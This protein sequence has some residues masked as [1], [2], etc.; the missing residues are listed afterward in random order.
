MPFDPYTFNPYDPRFQ[1]LMAQRMHAMQ[2]AQMPPQMQGPPPVAGQQGGMG[3]P[4]PQPQMPAPNSAMQSMLPGGSQLDP[5]MVD[6]VLALQGQG[7]QRDSVSRQY[8]L[9]DALR[10]SARDQ[11]QS[12]PGAKL[13]TGGTLHQGPT[14]VNGLS[15]VAQN[16]KAGQMQDAADTS[17]KGLDSQRQAAAKGFLAAL[18]RGNARR[19]PEAEETEGGF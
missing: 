6:Q 10:A 4:G 14:W 18:S 17:A 9:A 1:Q 8:K 15:A 3:G 19:K 12:G 11:L 2:P 13:S 7:S 5:E 16:W